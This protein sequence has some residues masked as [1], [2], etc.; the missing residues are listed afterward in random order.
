MSRKL[1]KNVE[2]YKE[3]NRNHPGKT[4]KLEDLQGTEGHST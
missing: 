1:G 2:R 4:T 3:E